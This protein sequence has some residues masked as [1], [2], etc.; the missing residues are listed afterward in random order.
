MTD[1]YTEQFIEVGMTFKTILDQSTNEGAGYIMMITPLEDFS[2][3]DIMSSLTPKQ[4]IEV[5]EHAIT[6]IKHL[7]NLQTT[8]RFP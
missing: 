4:Q 2:K 7:D 5:L 6:K 3:A 8:K 1:E